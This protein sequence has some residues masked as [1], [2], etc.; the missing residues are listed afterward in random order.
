MKSNIF[1]EKKNIKLNQL[2]P[3]EKFKVNFNISGIK[4]LNSAKKLPDFLTGI[5]I[6]IT[7]MLSFFYWPFM[8]TVY[9][10]IKSDFIFVNPI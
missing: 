7:P 3:K 6:S 9:N 8:V 5:Y 1:F 2:F 4:P 10:F